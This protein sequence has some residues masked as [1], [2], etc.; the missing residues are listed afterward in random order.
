MEKHSVVGELISKFGKPGYNASP[1][2]RNTIER[3]CMFLQD[4]QAAMCKDFVQAA[5]ATP[6][7]RFFSSDGTPIRTHKKIERVIKGHRV[8]REGKQTKEYLCQLTF[9]RRMSSAPSGYDNFV[10][11]KPPL[12]LPDKSALAIF[13][14]GRQASQTLRAQGHRGLVVEHMSF[15]RAAYHALSVAFQRQHEAD[16]WKYGDTESESS[17]L[18]WTEWVVSAGCALHDAHNSLKWGMRWKSQ[19]PQLLKD[20]WQ[21]FAALRNSYDLILSNVDHWLLNH[22]SWVDATECAPAEQMQKV[23]VALGVDVVLAEQLAFYLRLR[24]DHHSQTLHVCK[25]VLESPSGPEDVVTALLGIWKF[26]TF[27]DSRW[28]TVGICC[29][30]LVAGLLSG[31][32][33]LIDFIKDKNVTKNMEYH[34]GGWNKLGDTAIR[35]IVLSSL[36]SYVPDAALG[37]LF[38]D[39]R[40]VKHC[41]AV[42][43]SMVDELT[44]LES[45]DDFIW[46]TLCKV[47]PA[48]VDMSHDRLRS[49][50]LEAAHVAACFFDWRALLPA[51]SLPWSLVQGDQVENLRRLAE[52]PEPREP[53]AWKIWQLVHAGC[54]NELLQQ[55]LNLMGEAPWTTGSTEQN[56][57]M[58]AVVKRLHKEMGEE[59]LVSRAYIGGFLK[60]MPSLTMEEKKIVKLARRLS[61]LTGKRPARLHGRHI[62]YAD[63][64]DILTD[65]SKSRQGVQAKLRKVMAE[66]G[67]VYKRLSS[68]QK[69]GYENQ[70][71]IRQAVAE[72]ERAM[73][74]DSTQSEMKMWASR[75]DV[76]KKVQNPISLSTARLS[77]EALASLDPTWDCYAMSQKRCEERVREG[78]KAPK[79]APAPPEGEHVYEAPVVRNPEAERPQ[80]LG[81]VCTHRDEFIRSVWCVVKGGVSQFYRFLFAFQSP[82]H[83]G[84]A[85]L[86]RVEG[87]AIAAAIG[88]LAGSND[89]P[90]GGGA[91]VQWRAQPMNFVD[92]S[93]M[94]LDEADS[95]EVYS[96][97]TCAGHC[98]LAGRQATPLGMLLDLLP[99]HVATEPDAKKAT[100]KFDLNADLCAQFPWLEADRKKATKR[101]TPMA[102]EDGAPD[103]NDM[104]DVLDE[105]FPVGGLDDDLLMGLYGRLEQKRAEW[106]N[107]GML[108]TAHDAFTLK[109][110]KG[111]WCREHLGV[112]YDSIRFEVVGEA[113]LVWCAK[114]TLK[115]NRTWKIGMY[116][117]DAPAFAIARTYCHKM[118]YLYEL[119]LSQA[120]P[121]YAYTDADLD[122]WKV[123][124]EFRL[125]EAEMT[126]RQRPAAREIF[127]MR[128][129]LL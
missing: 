24:W 83:I 62:F 40:L 3:M 72:Q 59:Q 33:S 99:D 53:T 119:Y 112:D 84:F 95:I 66:H 6:T 92:W 11:W 35:F 94:R 97:V 86:T 105:E 18:Y 46:A 88:A 15:D 81:K 52:G 47:F 51:T 55:G 43:E 120:N 5:E 8:K 57:A 27:S 60:V 4:T 78:M 110:R 70:A 2:D 116:G 114:Y 122:A 77:P 75:L 74:V 68:K 39:S 103:P 73:E 56:H 93:V 85:P 54:S 108:A 80:W 38:E 82:L 127:Q 48:S 102:E 109:V 129:R 124:E 67:K 31:L 32:S 9:Y 111:K 125:V 25:D 100:Q 19:D 7:L 41:D 96:K 58:A 21:V 87:A 115:H 89:D 28:I 14:A 91:V 107:E 49:E 45:M 123:P 10:C 17:W 37:Q 113:P 101:T 42:R 61:Q 20:V 121:K 26:K 117:G 106:D 23:W 16:S 79:A 44:W 50:V 1:Q 36:A 98:T 12:P 90:Q 30:S 65:V 13:A 128:P 34:L 126:A 64:V 63:M 71:A 76:Q 104:V 29:R 118:V 22:V 69:A